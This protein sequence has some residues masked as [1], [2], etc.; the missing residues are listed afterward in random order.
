MIFYRESASL[1]LNCLI[2]FLRILR[3]GSLC[4]LKMFGLG[5]FYRDR[6]LD[7]YHKHSLQTAGDSAAFER[8]DALL[9]SFI[10]SINDVS[11]IFHKDFGI[12]SHYSLFHFSK[13]STIPKN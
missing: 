12:S 11:S 5:I 9:Y 2:L 6:V 8:R 13:G 7:N 4:I 1:Y 10:R 3:C